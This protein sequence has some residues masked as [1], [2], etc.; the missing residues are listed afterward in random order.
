[1]E[2]RNISA[3]VHFSH[4]LIPERKR[5]LVVYRGVAREGGRE[6]G[7][8]RVPVTPTSFGSGKMY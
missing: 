7:C 4:S 3:G 1:M 8:S 5:L 2:T 6:G